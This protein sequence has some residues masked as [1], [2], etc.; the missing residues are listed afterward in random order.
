MPALATYTKIVR[1]PQL[2]V[3]EASTV[4]HAA[5]L[6]WSVTGEFTTPAIGRTP[7]FLP[8]DV[9]LVNDDG[10]ET[11]D[12]LDNLHPTFVAHLSELAVES[13]QDDRCVA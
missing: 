2:R 5:G 8:T 6:F 10:S 11:E 13:L 3:D 1:R 4:V 7:A 9:R 12:M